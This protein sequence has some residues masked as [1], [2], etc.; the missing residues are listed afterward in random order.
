MAK[1]LKGNELNS[2]IEKIFEDAFD[3]IVIISPY[4][5]LHERYKDSLLD[6]LKY[7][8]L[9]I[10]LLFGKNE[11]NLS[12]SIKKEDLDFF[13]QFPN[14]K[15][16]YE[17]R[18]HAKYYA[19]EYKAILTSMNLYGFSQNNNIEAGVLMESSRK[20]TFTGSNE[21]DETTWDYFQRVFEQAELLFQK[22]PSFSKSNLLTSKKYLGSE[23]EVNKLDD[24]FKVNPSKQGFKTKGPLQKTNNLEKTGYCIR[25]GKPIPFNLE[26]P[27]DNYA[28]K[29]WSKYKDVEYPEKY[30]HYSGELSDGKTSV[31][32]PILA[33]NWKSAKTKFN[34]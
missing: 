6:K 11:D 15:I 25:T 12:K 3:K 27:L 23:M 22:S 10:L 33:K 16:S 7:P 34:L 28:F 24:Y 32:R 5:Q 9:E 26:K 14:I 18:L 1:F 4:I 19:N 2:E 13:I 20:G 31:K 30:C 21:L 29:M 8:E 17:K